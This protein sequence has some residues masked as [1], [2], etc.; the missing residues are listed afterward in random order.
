MVTLYIKW[1]NLTKE[2]RNQVKSFYKKKEDRPYMGFN[3]N[4]YSYKVNPLN[5]EVRL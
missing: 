2:Q 3:Q 4:E 1:S 5:G